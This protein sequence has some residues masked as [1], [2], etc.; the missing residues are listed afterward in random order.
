MRRNWSSFKS[1]GWCFLSK[2]IHTCRWIDAVKERICK[3]FEH[4]EYENEDFKSGFTWF[5]GVNFLANGPSGGV[6]GVPFSLK[7]WSELSTKFGSGIKYWDAGQVSICWRG[8]PKKDPL[9]T[10]K[11]FKYRLNRFASHVDGLIPLGTKKRRFV[12]E[13]HAFILGIPIVNNR[14]DSAPLVVWEGSHVIFRNMFGKVFLNIPET[15]F[16][17]MDLTEIY[18]QYRRKVFL[19]CRPK[20]VVP[21]NNQLYILDRHLLH[22]VTPWKLDN[23][24]AKWHYEGQFGV[25]PLQGRIVVYFRPSYKDPIDWILKN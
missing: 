2:D 17:D 22:G 21:A 15:E 1:K 6:D 3:K 25:N 5:A 16:C 4:A 10:E 7:L 18:Q 20:Q 14:L 19:T 24:L 11:S 13:F 23:D 9:E 8:Y 12:N